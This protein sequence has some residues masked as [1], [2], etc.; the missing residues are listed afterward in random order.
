MLLS[1]LL[2]KIERHSDNMDFKLRQ[3]F[4]EKDKVLTELTKTAK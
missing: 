4:L 3:D 1:L 2:L